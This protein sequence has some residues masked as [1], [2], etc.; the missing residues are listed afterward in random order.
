MENEGETSPDPTHNSHKKYRP[1]I[2]A[3]KDTIPK[4]CGDDGSMTEDALSSVTSS[5]QAGSCSRH[6]LCLQNKK[7]KKDMCNDK[8]LLVSYLCALERISKWSDTKVSRIEAKGERMK[9]SAMLTRSDGLKV[10]LFPNSGCV[11]YV[12]NGDYGL[13][14]WNITDILRSGSEVDARTHLLLSLSATATVAQVQ[15][16]KLPSMFNMIKI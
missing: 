8:I 2:S 15:T 16:N 4:V 6:P 9:E 12:M 14:L 1:L 10:N 7:S 5:V 11:F 13:K 3:L